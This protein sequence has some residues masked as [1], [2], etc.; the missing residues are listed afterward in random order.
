MAQL[1]SVI[2]L[3]TRFSILLV[4]LLLGEIHTALAQG[5]VPTYI[6]LSDAECR[7]PDASRQQLLVEQPVWRSFAEAH[8]GWVAEFNGSTGLPKRAYGPAIA[9]AGN[10]AEEQAWSFIHAELDRFGIPVEELVHTSTSSGPKLSYVHFAQEHQGIAVLRARLRITLDP[11]RGVIAFS[12]DLHPEISVQPF[13]IKATRTL[14]AAAFGLD[15]VVG[16]VIQGRAILPLHSEAGV[17]YLAVYEVLV[18]TQRGATPGRYNTLV[19]AENER[20][21]YRANEVMDHADHGHGD[22]GEDE[23]LELQ[24]IANVMANGPLGATQS[25]GMPNMRV[26][27]NGSNY[28][29]AP[30]GSLDLAIPGP[31]TATAQLRGRWSIITTNGV[32]ASLS[33]TL[34]TGIDT[35][36]LTSSSTIRERSA[37]YSVDR[38]HGHSKAVLPAFSGMDFPLPTK[39]D[40]SGNSCNAFYDGTSINLYAAGNGCRAYALMHDVVYHEYA[41]GINDKYYQSLSAAFV[42]GAMSEGYADLWA[43]TLTGQPTIGKGYQTANTELCIRRYDQAPRIY[44]QDLVAQV[45]ADGQIIAGAWWSTYTLLDDMDLMLDLWAA[46]LPGLQAMA[47]SGEEGT[48][49]R[50]VLLD[51][52]QADDDDG[53]ITNGTPHGAAIVQGFA[54]HGIT[55]LSG[56]TLQHAPVLSALENITIPVSVSATITFPANYYIAGLK[57]FYRTDATGPWQSAPMNEL[58]WGQYSAAI[59]PQVAGTLVS[60]YFG[61]EDVNGQLGAVL[62]LAA[63]FQS[64]PNVPYFV[65]VGME[66]Q[67]TA[68]G[69]QHNELGPFTAGLPTDNATSGQWLLAVPVPSFSGT[70]GTG[71][72]V[73]PGTQVTPGGTQCWVTGN[74]IGPN[75][76]MGTADVDGGVTTLI[77]STIDL[78]A[79]SDPVVVYHRWY[80]NNPQGGSNPNDD[81]WQVQVSGNAGASWTAV[82]ETKLGQ[83]AWRRMAFRVSDHVPVNDLFRIRFMASDSLRPQQ[84]ANGGSIVEAAVDDIQ[85]WDAAAIST[86]IGAMERPSTLQIHPVPATDMLHVSVANGSTLPSQLKVLDMAGRVVL[87][88]TVEPRA[89]H[90]I[91]DLSKLAAGQYVLS[92]NGLEGEGQ[93]RFSVVR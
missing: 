44:P 33:G 53:N 70:N 60:Y 2:G 64:D 16:A 12:A 48:A 40:V 79:M 28:F 75:E 77:S 83:I 11:F 69:D 36:D 56:V 52:L 82:E 43:M 63:A 55:L 45:H 15:A 76:P 32:T 62:P 5:R 37:F 21:L 23:G 35:L 71:Y 58:S 13:S 81:L 41:H 59:P 17:S 73:Q 89:Q 25:V 51:A 24:V 14:E 91:L 85:I 4:A 29:T 3:S 39:V 47:Y 46:T 80:L 9:V 88:F 87:S 20:I 26:V 90:M 57:L 65:L 72:K 18:H 38:I 92:F 19:D 30:D 1:S 61:M 27:A 78:S 6:P 34:Q 66:L 50:D 8:S 7:V 93:Q 67:A 68:D 84:N 86:G 22:E 42:N 49:F 10:S 54:R 31:L 74:A